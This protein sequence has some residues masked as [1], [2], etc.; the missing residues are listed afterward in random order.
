MSELVVVRR[1]KPEF[2]SEEALRAFCMDGSERCWDLAVQVVLAEHELRAALGQ[3]PDGA[4]GVKSK[5]KAKLVTLHLRGAAKVL[6][7]ASGYYGGTYLAF[8]KL[9]A[10]E[11]EQARE[12]GA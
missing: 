5:I 3:I 1:P 4:L 9:Y 12:D 11:R 2:D 6:D 7:L 10:K 8:T